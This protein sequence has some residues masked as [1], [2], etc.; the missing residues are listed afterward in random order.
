MPPVPRR[1]DEPTA[2]RGLSPAPIDQRWTATPSIQHPARTGEPP[3]A[4]SLSAAGQ[5]ASDD[6][7][8][9]KDLPAATRS[10]SGRSLTP[11]ALS[12]AAQKQPT[13]E[14]KATKHTG[15]SP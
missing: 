4:P 6:A 1:R 11:T 9:V 5:P 12:D 10:A 15:A 2:L 13:P 7:V 14:E 8:G 3:E